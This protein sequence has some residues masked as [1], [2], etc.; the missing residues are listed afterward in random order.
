[1][2]GLL[3]LR[4]CGLLIVLVVGEI[5]LVPT[6]CGVWI[7]RAVVLGILRAVVGTGRARG[8]AGRA[9]RGAGGLPIA[10]VA[11][12]STTTVIAIAPTT[13]AA[14]AAL[15]RVF[16]EVLIL[17][18]HVA[19]QVLAQGL[20]SL[21]LVRVGAAFHS[22]VQGFCVQERKVTYATCRNMGSS[23]SRWVL[24]SMKPEPRPLI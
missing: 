9:G 11:T 13:V 15:R 20:G 1:M 16:F 6:V 8:L 10:V 7:G 3:L 4:G 5:I 12:V 21:D 24:L 18:L 2:R 17:L 23:L 19:E 14:V 22:L